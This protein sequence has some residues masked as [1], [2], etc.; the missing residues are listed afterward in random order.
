MNRM[1]C[2]RGSV[3]RQTTL[4]TGSLAAFP[5]LVRAAGGG[6]TDVIRLAVIGLGN[7]AQHLKVG[8]GDPAQLEQA[9]QWARGTY[10]APFTPPV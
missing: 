6:A 5:V 1:F 7:K 3:L 4:Q 8:T 10:R 9:R 2:N